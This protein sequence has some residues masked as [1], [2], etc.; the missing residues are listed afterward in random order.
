VKKW[1]IGSVLLGSLVVTLA[2]VLPDVPPK[3]ELRVIGT[4]IRDGVDWYELELTNHTSH[5]LHYMGY[6]PTDPHWEYLF[7]EGGEWKE[8]LGYRCG[9]GLGPQT[10]AP[11]SSVRF[12]ITRPLSIPYRFGVNLRDPDYTYGKVRELEW[13]PDRIRTWAEDWQKDWL[14]KRWLETVTWTT[15]L[16]PVPYS[17]AEELVRAALEDG[18]VM[19]FANLLEEDPF[20]EGPPNLDPSSDPFAPSGADPFAPARGGMA[21]AAPSLLNP[22]APAPVS[23]STSP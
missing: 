3:A 10:L 4:V 11:N 21:P 17:P 15:P 19:D 5:D 23:A 12:T 22:F 6:E 16:D 8:P 1:I 20:A 9:H 2:L 18:V 7:W 13:L 14:H